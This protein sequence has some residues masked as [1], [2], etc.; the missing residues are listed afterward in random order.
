MD[1]TFCM[2][3]N[4]KLVDTEGN[5]QLWLKVEGAVV[6]IQVDGHLFLFEGDKKKLVTSHPRKSFSLSI[7]LISKRWA[8][9][10][11]AIY[12]ILVFSLGISELVYYTEQHIAPT[13]MRY[14]N[15]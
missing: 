14:P 13:C 8:Y 2:L 7:R 9:V 15:Y 4:V 10:W 11:S 1:N 6:Y 5:C 3:V 12:V